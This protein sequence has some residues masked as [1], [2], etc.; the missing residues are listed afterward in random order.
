[1]WLGLVS[2]I[3]GL[4]RWLRKLENAALVIVIAAFILCC[5]T[6]LYHLCPCGISFTQ[7]GETRASLYDS[8][9][10]SLST[11]LALIVSLLFVAVQLAAQAYTPRVIKKHFE[12]FHFIFVSLVFVFSILWLI[13]IAGDHPYFLNKLA[14]IKADLAVMLS[15]F[16]FVLLIPLVI[17]TYKLMR[18]KYLLEELVDDISEK[19]FE[20]IY[21]DARPKQFEH[22]RL[23]E[24]KLEAKLQPIFDIV[25]GCTL[26]G[27]IQTVREAFENMHERLGRMIRITDDE[28]L[29]E[30]IAKTLGQRML[31]I[32]LFANHEGKIELTVDTLGLFENFFEDYEKATKRASATILYSRLKEVKQD[33][34]R[35]YT[36][37]RYP[38]QYRQIT[39]MFCR[40]RSIL[41]SIVT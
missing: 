40:C 11:V 1:M 5:F 2:V 12:S 24:S 31:E 36:Q 28:F 35:K 14:F 37:S 33:F 27:D 22:V 26:K 17:R 9:L 20:R 30:Q 29:S 19:D 6:D 34:D 39:V 4:W 10:Q 41:A 13:F 23:Q 21:R 25:R 18:P 32:G 3:K 7:N 8:L 15:S 38:K 16:S